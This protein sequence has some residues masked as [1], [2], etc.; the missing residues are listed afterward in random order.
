[1]RARSK[2]AQIERQLWHGTSPESIDSINTNGFNR[3]YCGKNGLFFFSDFVLQMLH[4]HRQ[5]IAIQL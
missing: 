1:M 2:T 3:S 5:R 4:L